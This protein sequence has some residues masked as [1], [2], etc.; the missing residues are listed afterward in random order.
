MSQKTKGLSLGRNFKISLFHL[1]SGMADVLSTGVWNRIMISDLGFE[2]GPVGLLLSLRYFLTPL[3]IWAG[4]ISDRRTILGF[5]RLFWIWL[6]RLLMVLSTVGLGFV[7]ARLVET[8]ESIATSWLMIG[9]AL[10]AFSLGNAISGSTF[11]AL[12]YDRSTE[13]QRG[14]AVGIVWTML[15]VGF[16]V[17]G[18]FF[19][20]ALP[21]TEG[22]TEL[23][24]TAADLLRLFLIGAGIFAVL[25]FVSLFGEERRRTYTEFDAAPGESQSIR[26]DLKL[27]WQDRS[28]RFFLI[29]LVGSMFFAFSQ[30]IILEPFAADVFEMP[31]QVTNRFAAYWGGTAIL[32]SLLFLWLSR[33]VRWFDT[34]R[35]SV[36]GT[37]I[38]FVTFILLA[39]SG[40]AQI[41]QMVTPALITLGLGLGMWN[42]GT[43]GLMMDF[44]PT[45][46]A[47][48]FLGF[49]TMCVTLARGAGVGSG[50]WSRDLWLRITQEPHLAYG[51]VFAIGAVGLA[52]SLWAVS[53]IDVAGFKRANNG[54]ED[55]LSES[56]ETAA[57]LAGAME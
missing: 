3:G 11:L 28:M 8:G 51:L 35:M 30:D 25:W 53:Q 43:L 44:S 49:W 21:S 32:G 13:E 26:E 40:M 41:R 19:G 29:Y 5:R 31:A 34:K 42:I 54:A 46:G 50:G 14:R 47:G 36:I 27:V 9:A 12:I 7:T 23:S 17:G 33:R 24:F 1:G 6:G 37:F 52:F 57:I 22:A 56:E 55:A 2:A 4:R 48:T 20:V 45:G 10:V 16:T 18:I 38:L 15:L 39:I